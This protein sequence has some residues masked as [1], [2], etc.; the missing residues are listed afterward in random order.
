MSSAPN[1]KMKDGK[2]IPTMG[3]GTWNLT[4]DVSQRMVEKALELGY[5]HIDTA[6]S[7]GNESRIGEAIK[8]TTARTYL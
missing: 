4:G 8:N 2:E 3:L 7:Y 5:T 6:E 1:L